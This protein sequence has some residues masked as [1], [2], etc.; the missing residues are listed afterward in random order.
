MYYV[1]Y[2]NT[3]TVDSSTLCV[4]KREYSKLPCQAYKA[5]LNN[6]EALGEEGFT[7]EVVEKFF[8]LAG[9]VELSAVIVGSEPFLCLDLRNPEGDDISQLL[10]AEEERVSLLEQTEECEEEEGV[11]VSP[12]YDMRPSRL[13]IDHDTSY[14]NTVP[15]EELVRC[16]KI[17]DEGCELHV[18]RYENTPYVLSSEISAL[19][20]DT[21]ILRQMLQQGGHHDIQSKF[22]LQREHKPLFDALSKYTIHGTIDGKTREIESIYELSVLPE[23]CSFFDPIH[24]EVGC[25]V[26]EEMRF[27]S[28]CLYN[29]M[30]WGGVVDTNIS[31]EA[32][33][34]LQIK[35]LL[36]RR[37]YHI[38]FLKETMAA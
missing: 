5:T 32:F 17:N 21:D 28:E 7:K 34:E 20:W 8:S 3:A 31:E 29:E 2:G 36:K 27:W 15:S 9:D 33:L 37:L 13:G 12:E 38:I 16:L 6:V 14:Y 1:D 22:L 18:I 25:V 4:L 30:Y 11:C 23:I 24:R 26:L 19:F 35:F 10:I